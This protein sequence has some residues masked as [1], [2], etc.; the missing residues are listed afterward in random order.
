M[1][2]KLKIGGFYGVFVVCSV[3]QVVPGRGLN[4]LKGKKVKKVKG[5]MWGHSG[6]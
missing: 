1:I 5:K 3:M 4:H 2:K 6:E